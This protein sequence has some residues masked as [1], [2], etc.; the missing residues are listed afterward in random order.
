MVLSEYEK[1]I[2][3]HSRVIDEQ[4]NKALYQFLYEK[5]CRNIMWLSTTFEKR[6]VINKIISG[7]SS[8]APSYKYRSI[9]E[10]LVSD[11]GLSMK[12]FGIIPEKE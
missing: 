7:I 5:L 11:V 4:Q 1:F 3:A 9:V 12:H 6:F 10:R 8:Y 2:R